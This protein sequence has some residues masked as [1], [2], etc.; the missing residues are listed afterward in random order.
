MFFAHDSTPSYGICA[1]SHPIHPSVFQLCDSV[2][3]VIQSILLVFVMYFNPVLPKPFIVAIIELRISFIDILNI[4]K[5]FFSHSTN[6][7][8]VY[9]PVLLPDFN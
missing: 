8:R 1:R 7:S 6:I 5:N 4:E 9:I 3:M 2:Y